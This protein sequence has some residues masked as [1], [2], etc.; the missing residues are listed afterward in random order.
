VV[1]TRDGVGDILW[2]LK[3]KEKIMGNII[4][5]I[6]AEERA[7]K[8]SSRRMKMQDKEDSM[9]AW[10]TRRLK[11][12]IDKIARGLTNE[13]AEVLQADA[14][15]VYTGS[16]SEYTYTPD[17]FAFNEDDNSLN[18]LGNFLER[19]SVVSLAKK[20]VQKMLVEQTNE[21]ANIAN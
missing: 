6:K 1:L 4:K 12:S 20:V 9:Y 17:R 8:V 18:I 15:E 7:K 21:A 11:L 5:E 19:R 3:I 14:M 10:E 2:K 13:Q 16:R